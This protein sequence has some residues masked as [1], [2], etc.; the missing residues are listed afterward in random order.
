[1]LQNLESDKKIEKD[2]GAYISAQLPIQEF[3]LQNRMV[4]I[5]T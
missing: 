4:H 3:L 5:Y 2:D 1:M